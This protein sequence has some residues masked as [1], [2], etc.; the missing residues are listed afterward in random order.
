MINVTVDK[1]SIRFKHGSRY[2]VTNIAQNHEPK[3]CD[4]CG[5]K[6]PSNSYYNLCRKC[7][8]QL[9][10]EEELERFNKAT[11]YKLSEC[12]KEKRKLM[13]SEKYGNN[14]GYFGI[15][16]DFINYC[17]SHNTEVPKYVWGTEEKMISL[18]ALDVIA[19]GCYGLYHG[20]ENSV[21]YDSCLELQNFLDEWCKKQTGTITPCPDYSCAILLEN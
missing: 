21:N 10:A 2:F 6:I 9:N 4:R 18:N 15:L 8:E 12:P 11:K 20:A 3:R 17:K 1:P 16:D 5:A 13:Y 14:D 19:L 7:D